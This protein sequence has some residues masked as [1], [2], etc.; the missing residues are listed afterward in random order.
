MKHISK[1]VFKFTFV[2]LILLFVFSI[3]TNKLINKNFDSLNETDKNMLNQLSQV[4]KTYNNSSKDIWKEGYTFNNIPLILTPTNKDRGIIHGYSYVIG[5]DKL[6]NSIFSKKIEI[7]KEM[8]LPPVYRV[9]FLCPSLYQTW[10]PI[11][12]TF[13]DIGNQ[14]AMLFKYHPNIT[15]VSNE[16]KSYKYFLMHEAFHEYRQVP[17]WK[18]VNDLQSVIHIEDRNKEQYQLLLTEISILD[19]AYSSKNKEELLSTL[20]DFITVRDTRYNKFKYMEQEKKVETLEGCA[21]YI[22][23]KYSDKVK[24]F[25]D[26]PFSSNGKT[27]K[28]SDTIFSEK[29]LEL[30]INTG[31]LNG[32]MDKD[33]YYYIGALEGI[34]LDKLQINWKDKVENNKLIYDII[35]DEVEKNVENNRKSIEDIK[36]EYGY[37]DFDKQAQIIIKNLN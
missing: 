25:I 23:Y 22:E 20:R 4:Y 6:E 3:I 8:K 1:K 37:D 13:A 36:H 18:N 10:L 28:F 21:T 24:D 9:S 16:K 12:F 26:L 14:H 32:L 33:L 2:A 35:R 29:A 19:K 34:L 7:P 30:I 31:S 17:I 27:Y 15:N 5:V 11:N